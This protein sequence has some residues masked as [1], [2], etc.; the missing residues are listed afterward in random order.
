MILQQ[1]AVEI[2]TLHPGQC[3]SKWK[4]QIALNITSVTLALLPLHKK[5]NV[6]HLI[7]FDEIDTDID[8][9][10]LLLHTLF[11]LS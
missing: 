1:R 9:F 3:Q 8:N 6:V 4:S 11:F 7:D 5:I 10:S 2:D